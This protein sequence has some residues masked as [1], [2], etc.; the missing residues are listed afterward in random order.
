[1]RAVN[2]ERIVQTNQPVR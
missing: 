2:Y 1:M